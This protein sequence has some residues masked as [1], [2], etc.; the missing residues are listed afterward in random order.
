MFIQ[1]LKQKNYQLLV[2]V[3]AGL[4]TIVSSIPNLQVKNSIGLPEVDKVAHIVIFGIFAFLLM[5]SIERQIR[6]RKVISQILL[7][8]LLTIIF[9]CLDEIHQSFVA[10]RSC[11]LWDLLADGVGGILGATSYK[12]YSQHANSIRVT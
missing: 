8:L 3:W 5:G 1:T 12:I 2:G 10:G 7:V 6:S 11:S 9:G 4:I